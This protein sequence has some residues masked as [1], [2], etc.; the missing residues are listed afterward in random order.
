MKTWQQFTEDVKSYAT[1]KAAYEKQTASKRKL[2]AKRKAMRTRMASL[3][4][5]FAQKSKAKKRNVEYNLDQF[6]N[7]YEMRREITRAKTRN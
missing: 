7:D 1:D 6:K 4:K 5:K 3:A 2:D